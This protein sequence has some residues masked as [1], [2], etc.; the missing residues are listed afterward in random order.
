MSYDLAFENFLQHLFVLLAT[1]CS[2]YCTKVSKDINIGLLQ[3]RSKVA[4]HKWKQEWVLLAIHCRKKCGIRK[5]FQ[6]VNS[7]AHDSFW[8]YFSRSSLASLR[9]GNHFRQATLPYLHGLFSSLNLRYELFF[10]RE[11]KGIKRCNPNK[12]I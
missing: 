8:K 4:K 10:K 5:I 2:L 12:V 9:A 1:V 7:L 11:L 6:R 3:G